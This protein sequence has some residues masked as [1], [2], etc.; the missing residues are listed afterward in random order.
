MT[1]NFSLFEALLFASGEPLKISQISELL[2]KDNTSN[3]P[4]EFTAFCEWYNGQARG[5]KI[6]KVAGGMQ[7]V[8][9]PAFSDKIRQLRT[10]RRKTRFSRAAMEVLAIIAYKQPVTTPEIENIRGVDSSGVIKNLLEKKIITISGRKKGPGNPLLYGTTSKFL[11]VLGLDDLN[12]LPSLNEFEAILSDE[13]GT[14]SK[15][16][17]IPFTKSEYQTDELQTEIINNE[18]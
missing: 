17:N 12:S 5:L 1:Q 18:E 3:I 16:Q 10:R 14:E 4:D 9:R 7:L 13:I 8:T 2:Q 11:I 6:V 15:T